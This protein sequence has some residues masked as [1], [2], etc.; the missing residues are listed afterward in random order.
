MGGLEAAEAR[1]RGRVRARDDGRDQRAARA[2]RRAHRAR[3]DRGLPRRDRDRPP[4]PR[5]R[6]TTSPSAA[7]RRSCRA[8]C[9]SRCASGWGPTASS[10]RSTR[11]SVDGGGRRAARGRGRGGR[12]LPAV[13][14]PAPRARAARS[15]RRSARRCRTCTCR[16]RARC[17]PSSA[18]TSASRPRSPTPT[19][20][21]R[22]A[23]LPASGS[24]ERAARAPACPRRWSC[25]PRAAWS[26]SA[27]AAERRRRAACS[28]GR[29]AAWSAPR[30]VARGERLRGP[31]HLRHGRHE[32]RRRAGRSAARRRPRPS[33]VVGRRADQAADGRRPHGQ[34]RRRLDR[35]GRRAAARCASGRARRAPTPGPAAY[36]QGGEEP[37]VTDANL[38]LGYLAR[39]RRARRRGR[40]C[41]REPAEQALARARR[42]SSA[43][44]RWR[45][46]SASCASP[47]PRWCRAL[48][49]ISRRAR[50]RPAR[51]RA[52]RLRRRRRA[53]TPARWPRS[54]ASRRVLVPRAGGVLSALGLAISDLRRDYVRAAARRRSTSSTRRGSRSR[55]RRWR[56]AAREDLDGPELRRL[57][58]LRYRGQSFELTVDADDLDALAERFHAAH[59]RRYGYRM[60]ERAGRARQRRALIATV[61][62]EQARAAPR[63]SRRRTPTPATR[64]ANFDGDWVR[65]AGLRPRRARA[66][67]RASRARR[68]SSSPRRPASC[69]RAGP[70]AI[71]DVG[72]A[73]A[74]ARAERR[75]DPVTLSVLA[76]ALAGIAEEMGAV[77]DP[78]RLLLEHQGAPRLLGRAVRRRGPDGRPGRAHPRAPRRDARVGGRG[79]RARPR[80]RRRVRSS[81]TPT[82]AARTCPTSRSSRR[83]TSTARSLGY[84]VTRAH[85]SDVGGMRP[86]SMPA[87]LARD[88]P[89]GARHPAGAA[90]ARRRAT[91]TTL[92]ELMLANVRTPG[93]APRRPARAD[94][95]QPARRG[96]GC[97][98]LVERRGRDVVERRVRRGAR[99]RRA[100]H[101]RGARARCPTATLR[102]RAARS[103]A[104][105]STDDD[106][107]IAR[108]GRRST[109]TRCRST[110]T[111]TADQ[112]R[113]QRQLPARGDALGVLL[114]A[115]RAAARR[116]PGQ[117]RH[118]RGAR[119]R[120]ARGLA[121]QRAAARRRWWP[122]T[123]RPRQRDRRHRAGARSARRS[124]LPAAGP[125]HDEQPD[126]RRPR[127]DLLRDDRRR[128]GR[129]R[130]RRRAR[131]ASTSG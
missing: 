49:V 40:R 55:S 30:Y 127:L 32:H 121:G 46:R 47:T 69:G 1:G 10:S 124:T 29:P 52:R 81:T 67:A 122:A 80:A 119:D 112:V 16:S 125:G 83:S 13:R 85:H 53:C 98:E 79:D 18:S 106:I 41:D 5:R 20:R 44:T 70:G 38:L 101:A 108:R 103:R 60:D 99:L 89:G 57:A 23:R 43:S 116:R 27:T 97:D 54:S 75:L 88:L 34:R 3:D 117:R 126:H 76:S 74:G 129:E 59:E 61:P 33:P 131:P 110:S 102:G 95:R 71:D 19:S 56:S 120:G 48:R 128:P 39:R 72:H 37:T 86:G 9:A 84:A 51:V 12:R 123:S 115:A 14:V 92:L 66:R 4:G 28:P 107:P 6:S 15:A 24:R 58:D 2:P 90:R 21:P 7:R 68:S 94:R 31:A 50:P 100:A 42:A 118:L 17:C 96:S 65:G 109:A 78:R 25:S 35:L 105:A 62:V 36:G 26:T 63:T 104:T 91:T 130:R 93:H 114:R 113:R 82:A 64:A 111:G 11:T 87:G 73:R 77:L 8:S 45:P 22:L